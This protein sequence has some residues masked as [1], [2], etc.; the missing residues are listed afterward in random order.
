MTP[1]N[2]PQSKRKNPWEKQGEDK[3]SPVP[4]PWGPKRNPNEPPDIDDM[5]RKAQQNFRSVM[6]G[7][8]HP[9]RVAALVVLGVAALW[10]ASGFYI[11]QPGDQAVVQRFGAWE[12]TDIIEGLHYHLPAPV[13]IVTKV[14]VNQIRQMAIGYNDGG[15]AGRHDV[16]EESMML[17]AN[18]NIVDLNLVVQWNVKNAE[19]YL[20]SVKGPEDAIKKV[21][22]SAIREVVG[23][24]DMFPL[25][26]SQRKQVADRAKEILQKNLD[27]YKSGVNI[28]QVLIEKAEVHPEVQAAFQDVQS[29]KQDAQD[30]QNRAETYRQDILP[31]AR[32]QAI[33]MTQQAEAYRQSTI[34]KANGDAQ[35]FTL[36]QEAYQSAPDVTKERIYL[37]TME[38]VLHNAHKLIMDDKSGRGVIPYFPM[39]DAKSAPIA[40]QALPSASSSNANQEPSQP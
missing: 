9:Y 6:P 10:A 35:R 38:E 1:D 28:S 33:Q 29:A 21:A 7:D 18:R 3:N 4:T 30:V 12:R 26:T 16:T 17:T 14:N 5:L 19:D 40:P 25:I 13:E 11:V 23:Q 32:G 39:G 22:E 34:A 2:K 8:M 24:T 37:E 31:R 15:T 36:M 27:D 20:F